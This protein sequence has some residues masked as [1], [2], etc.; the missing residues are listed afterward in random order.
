MIREIELLEKPTKLHL[1]LSRENITL[2]D[3]THKK[4]MNVY[5]HYYYYEARNNCTKEQLKRINKEA[6][7]ELEELTEDI[8]DKLYDEFIP[9]A[10]CTLSKVF[11][12]KLVGDYQTY[13]AK[14]LP[15]SD[16]LIKKSGHWAL[17]FALQTALLEISPAHPLL[18]ATVHS[19]AHYHLTLEQANREGCRLLLKALH[20]ASEAL[21]T[22]KDHLLKETS[23]IY[24]WILEIYCQH[25][26]EKIEEEEV[27][28]R[29]IARIQKVNRDREMLMERQM[30]DFD[31]LKISLILEEERRKE[32]KEHMER[33]RVL[34]ERKK[35]LEE[36]TAREE[37]RRVNQIV[38]ED[39]EKTKKEKLKKILFM[40]GEQN[41]TLKL[42]T[43]GNN[44]F[45]N[46]SLLK[47]HVIDNSKGKTDEKRNYDSVKQ[48]NSKFN[49]TKC[50]N[51]KQPKC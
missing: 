18:L 45:E 23:N 2:L 32:I 10:K 26:K 44:S 36:L 49:K 51:I 30:E 46:G 12:Y 21:P 3:T 39:E 24:K 19:V 48:S 50:H 20:D 16:S 4:I 8:L 34:L 17:R 29:E 37:R 5:S 6:V 47:H 14:F 41:M 35:Y 33:L 15:E 9:N 40:P 22:M 31:Q 43:C 1:E 38:E 42:S 28:Q 7:K 25:Y 27:K 13:I 11:Y